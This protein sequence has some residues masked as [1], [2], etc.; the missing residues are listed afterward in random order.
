MAITGRFSLLSGLPLDAAEDRAPLALHIVL[1]N[2]IVQPDR[3]LP[4][5]LR[6]LPGGPIAFGWW[7]F[8]HGIDIEQV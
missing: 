1:R 2:Q 8:R 5:F 4:C 7:V 3:L 6:S